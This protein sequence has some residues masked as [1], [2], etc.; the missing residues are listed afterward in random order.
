VSEDLQLVRGMFVI[1]SLTGDSLVRFAYGSCAYAA[2][3]IMGGPSKPTQQSQ[4]GRLNGVARPQTPTSH[5]SPSISPMNGLEGHN[6]S[7][8]ARGHNQ[9]LLDRRKEDAG[10]NGPLI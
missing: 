7:P 1:G 6:S 10:A 4:T 3:K 8:H 9:K 2:G 5:A